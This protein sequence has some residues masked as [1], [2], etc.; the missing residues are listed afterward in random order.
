MTQFVATRFR[1]NERRLY[2]FHNDGE[3]VALGDF[4]EVELRDGSK[5][6]VEVAS[7]I[8]AKP[9]FPTAPVLSKAERPESW[10]VTEPQE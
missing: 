4:V 8:D 1:P 5:K 2:T 6:I 3:P 10:P 9:S 7:L